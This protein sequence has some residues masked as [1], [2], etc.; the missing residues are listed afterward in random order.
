MAQPHDPERGFSLIEVLI[1]TA[2]FVTGVVALF[3]LFLAA[4]ASNRSARAAT[5][6]AVL[7]AQKME[8][9]RGLTWGFDATGA[10][11]SDTTTDTSVVPFT[12]AGSGLAPSPPAALQQNTAGYADYLDL[13]GAWVGSG[14]AIPDGTVYIRR[15]SVEPLPTDPANA[16]LLQVLVTR[17]RDRGSADRGRVARLPD[18]ARLATVRTRKWR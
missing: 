10:P 8:Q 2:I 7:A 17:R 4:H 14:S 15:W 12:S 1:A 11:V 6:A 3:Q 5:G 18:E 16:V 9:L 13:Q